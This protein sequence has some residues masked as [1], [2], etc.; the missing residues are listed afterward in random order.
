MRKNL[1]I[2]TDNWYVKLK[3]KSE[4]NNRKI[5]EGIFD[6]LG[7]YGILPFTNLGGKDTVDLNNKN[8]SVSKSTGGLLLNCGEFA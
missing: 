8:V 1:C 5:T 6:F 3:R 4:S 2:C 7:R